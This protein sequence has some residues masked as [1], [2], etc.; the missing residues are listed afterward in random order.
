MR[1]MINTLSKSIRFQVEQIIK[2]SVSFKV[3][4]LLG[5]L[6]FAISLPWPGTAARQGSFQRGDVFVS[7]TDGLI[8]RYSPTSGTL[9]QTLDTGTGSGSFITGGAFDRNANFYATAFSSR[10]VIRFDANGNRLG[11]F[12]SGYNGRPESVIF[13]ADGN[14]YVGTVDGDNDIRKFDAAGNPLDRYDVA[15]ERRGT[16]WID[17]AAD[18]C[19]LYYTSEGARI[20]RYDVCTKTQLTDFVSNLPHSAAY[21]LRLL[22][23]GGLLVAD[24]N[25]VLRL[26]ATGNI[27]Q[28]YDAPGEDSWFAVNLD[29]DGTSFWSGGIST[30]NVY[31]FDI[32]TGNQITRI[33]TGQGAIFGVT[34]LGELTVVNPTPSPTA[35]ATATPTPPLD[36]AAD[37][38]VSK[39]VSP[40]VVTNGT[41]VT[42]TLRINN[43]GPAQAVNAV[44]TDTLPANTVFVSCSTSGNGTCAG[45]GRTRTVTFSVLP[46]GEVTVTLTVR[47]DCPGIESSV[48]TNNAQITAANVDPNP[49]NN[50]SQASVNAAPPQPRITVGAPGGFNFG[51]VVLKREGLANPQWYPFTIEN[52][53]CLPLTVAL[54]VQRT[55][56]DVS[57][58]R[59]SNA[60][61]KATFPVA[62][63]ANGAVQ[64]LDGGAALTTIPGGGRGEFRLYFNPKIPMAAGKTAGLSANQVIPDLIN[65]QLVISTNAPTDNGFARFTYP[66]TGRVAPEL[67]LINPLT[68]SLPPLV[69][70]ARNNDEFSVEFSVHDANMDTFC[71]TYQFL[72]QADVPVGDAPVFY[73]DEDIAK[74]GM[75][76][77][78]SFTV[79]KKFSGANRRPEVQRVRVTVHD[80]QINVVETSTNVGS[81]QGRVVNVSAASFTAQ[82]LAVE[83]I[84][85]AFGSKLSVETR[86]A[87]TTPLPFELAGTRVLITDSNNVEH[88]AP[89]FFVAPG[90]VNYMVPRGVANGPAIVTIAAAD[91]TISTG[92]ITVADV[93]PALFTADASGKGLP[94]GVVFR[95]KANGAQVYEPLAQF[96]TATRKFDSVAI[97]VSNNK[98]QVY[99]VLFGTGFRYRRAP[100][101]LRAT[102]GGLDAPV[103]FA[104]KQGGLVGVDQV[105]LLL[106]T[107][108]A[109]RGDVEIQLFVDGKAANPVRVQIR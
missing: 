71:A 9:L 57:N 60:D 53:G 92:D 4:L 62:L 93:A 55:G 14:A 69:V 52:V 44:L 85:A 54:G 22:P 1:Q 91:G 109:G 64:F 12:G 19:T 5:V 68:P 95:V 106:P 56:P 36:G 101:G 78:Q 41:L 80:R 83:S 108:L 6:T 7:L 23:S 32:A 65:S 81:Q 43:A 27:T 42:Y 88:A 94:T 105:N 84:V 26:D 100:Q 21:A 98:E 24:T 73:L 11:E 59:I 102:V 13:D 47:V 74:A 15:V 96:N 50:A 20:L 25:E 104:G 40:N 29:P 75:V 28:R 33:P 18:K 87:G 72:N 46:L 107:Q 30:G 2:Q 3:A 45:N 79:V 103:T 86:S 82:G 16:D 70:L 31:K 39:T 35:T 48:L 90:Q 89:L 99:L 77:G 63:V 38:S 58:G 37:L 17:L 49:G 51:E 10:T 76:R 97:D 67:K 61:D 34:V 8:Q 66:V